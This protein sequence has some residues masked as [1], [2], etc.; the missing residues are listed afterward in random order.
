MCM[1]CMCGVMG[2]CKVVRPCV[3]YVHMFA[4]SYMLA[5]MNVQFYVS[6]HICMHVAI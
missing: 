5:C 1:L 2:T 3:F 4:C 6:V